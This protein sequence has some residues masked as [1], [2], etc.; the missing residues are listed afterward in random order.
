MFA[1]TATLEAF[2]RR[3]TVNLRS[4]RPKAPLPL[5]LEEEALLMSGAAVAESPR[6]WSCSHGETQTEAG[7]SAY[8]TGDLLGGWIRLIRLPVP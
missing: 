1:V 4:T 5:S 7:T 8:E 2:G 6:R 3:L